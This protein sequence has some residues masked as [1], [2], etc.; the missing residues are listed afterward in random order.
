MTT[1]ELDRLKE[2]A[3]RATP[4]PW[5][6]DTCGDVWTIHSDFQKWSEDDYF[7]HGSIGT[8]RRGPDNG[9]AEYIAA[10]SP[11]VVLKLIAEVKLARRSYDEQ[12]TYCIETAK[13]LRAQLAEAREVI[14]SI[15][16]DKLH[17]PASVNTRNY[18]IARAYLDKWSQPSIT[19]PKCQKTS[20][21]PKDISEKYCGNCHE[22]WGNK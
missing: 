1:E 16:F 2:L 4:G 14:E 15:E 19:C 22:F 9:D 20:Y 7:F 13:S 5:Q 11:D 3:E 6:S 12:N 17:K 8:T 18:A 21:H 10:V